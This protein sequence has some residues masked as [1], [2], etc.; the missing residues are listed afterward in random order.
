M[1][2]GEDP[3]PG[4]TAPIALDAMGG[5]HAPG[6]LVAGAVA[7]AR[8]HRLPVSL[9]GRAGLLRDLLPRPAVAGIDVV[10]APDVIPMGDS[11][12]RLRGQPGSSAAVACGLLAAGQAAAVVSAGSTGGTVATAVAR[13]GCIPGV[14]RPAI[15]VLLPTAPSGTV[16]LDAGATADPTPEM[17]A[18]HAVLGAAY[19][20]AVLRV[21]SPAVGL[22]TIGS[23]PGKGNRLARRAHPLLC[24]A[25]VKFIGNLEGG[26]A[27][28]GAADVLV[29][30]GFTGNVLLKAVEG[31]LRLA[32]SETRAA[33]TAGPAGALA[34]LANRRRLHRLADR[35]DPNGQGGAVLLG[36]AGPVVIA[37]GSARARAITR[38]CLLAHDL[39]RSGLTG[40]VA[41][42]VAAAAAG[43]PR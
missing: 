5:D 10:H 43:L 9:A 40:Q 11:G 4:S 33:L 1:T 25:P 17:L 19:A 20:T 6:E 24:A 37:H 27:L 38:A 42:A 2:A 3:M 26:D 36:V 41:D 14:R 35:F 8:E 15:A 21:A 28:D 34:E 29:T 12:V 7:V 23:E 18:Q 30:D 22:L 31:S 39:A 32:L 13:L 16:L